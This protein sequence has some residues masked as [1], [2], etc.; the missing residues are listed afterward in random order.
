MDEQIFQKYDFKDG[1]LNKQAYGKNNASYTGQYPP[2]IDISKMKVP[3]AVLVGKIDKLA[4]VKDA[5]NLKSKIKNLV[6][7]QIL[8]GVDHIGMI[9][10]RWMPQGK[11]IVKLLK[12]G[13]VNMSLTPKIMVQKFKR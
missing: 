9:F 6:S 8:S 10:R 13:K 3:T 5:Q 2:E 1:N 4:T 7:F 12:K 11:N